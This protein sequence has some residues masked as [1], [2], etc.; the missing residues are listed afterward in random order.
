MS[1]KN[2][3]HEAIIEGNTK[4]ALD[5]IDS[6]ININEIDERHATPLILAIDFGNATIVKALIKA[7]ALP[8]PENYCL[9]LTTNSIDECNLDILDALIST[10]IDV[11]V[12][13]EDDKTALLYVARRRNF[14]ATKMLIEAGAD[15][16]VVDKNN[17]FA[18]RYA[19]AHGWQNM[20]NY[21]RQYTTDNELLEIAEKEFL[22]FYS[23]LT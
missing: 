4:Y 22:S 23:N 5:L 19:A 10:G 13:C 18:L 15:A 14:A 2:L 6:G 16:N 3:I 7:G 12:R 20:Y 8:I 9:E 21:L 1:S 17:N 11:N